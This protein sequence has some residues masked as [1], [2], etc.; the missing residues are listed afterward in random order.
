MAENGDRLWPTD[1]E[2]AGLSN[3]NRNA[4]IQIAINTYKDNVFKLIDAESEE[5]HKVKMANGLFALTS[6]KNFE[7]H[8][9]KHLS[10]FI[11][12]FPSFKT[13]HTVNVSCFFVTSTI[14]FITPLLR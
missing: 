11:S 4:T 13:S 12:I 6:S 3:E 1:K 5:L 2:V 10:S 14:S 7:S 8:K 9:Y